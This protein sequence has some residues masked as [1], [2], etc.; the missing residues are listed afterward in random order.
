ME[1]SLS[2]YSVFGSQHSPLL[3]FAATDGSQSVTLLQ[4]VLAKW[5]PYCGC[6]VN[7]IL[8]LD[9]QTDASMTSTTIYVCIWMHDDD[10]F[11]YLLRNKLLR[12]LKFTIKYSLNCH[13]KNYKYVSLLEYVAVRKRSAKPCCYARADLQE[14]QQNIDK[15]ER[16]FSENGVL[17]KQQ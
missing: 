7:G 2:S 6:T 17:I 3:L 11:A 4:Y 13:S 15:L 14:K 1:N 12:T 8:F 9:V 5:R 16:R 10:S